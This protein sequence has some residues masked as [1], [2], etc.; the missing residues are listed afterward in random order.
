MI[1][2]TA[3][4]SKFCVSSS[5]DKCELFLKKGLNPLLGYTMDG[6]TI[7]QFQV[8]LATHNW[9]LVELFLKHIKT[10]NKNSF[11]TCYKV[12]EKDSGK[13]KEPIFEKTWGVAVDRVM[14][15]CYNL[16]LT[17][18]KTTDDAVNVDI[19]LNGKLGEVVDL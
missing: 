8:A 15:A 1:N 18:F 2:N 6:K 7:N 14:N 13:V 12:Y 9:K 4:L 10:D 5:E 16:S 19:E 11:D 17:S 3:I